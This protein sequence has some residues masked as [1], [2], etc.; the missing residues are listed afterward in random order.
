MDR[1]GLARGEGMKP[2][3]FARQWG[4]DNKGKRL[5]E[6]LK[7]DFCNALGGSGIIIGG[8]AGQAVLEVLFREVVIGQNEMA[9]YPG[10]RIEA[11]DE[12]VPINFATPDENLYLFGT[13]DPCGVNYHPVTMPHKTMAGWKVCAACLEHL[14]PRLGRL[15]KSLYA[16]VMMERRTSRLRAQMLLSGVLSMRVQ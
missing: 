12:Y 11:A 13:S 3:D 9:G 5:T 1:V 7:D 6:T 8:E 14:P 15:R 4:R 10:V 16:A 2:S